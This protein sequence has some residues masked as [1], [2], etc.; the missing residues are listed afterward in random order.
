MPSRDNGRKQQ[1]RELAQM[2]T[3]V[4]RDDMA[5]IA[6]EA[7]GAAAR[8]KTEQELRTEAILA[9]LD[10]LGGAQVG[11]DSIVFA[12][13]RIILPEDMV[14]KMD[15]VVSFLMEY[16]ESQNTHFNISR[17]FPFRP[18]DVAAAFDRA[19]KRVF[20]VSGVGRAQFSFFGVT[21]PEYISVNAGPNGQ[22]IQVP[23]EKVEF[24]LLEA[25]FYLEKAKSPEHGVIGKIRVDA[26]KKH[27]KRIEGFF[28][29]VEEELHERSLYRGQAI[30]AHPTEPEFID[31]SAVD[32]KRVIYT[33]AVEEQLEV[34]LWAPLRYTQALR[35]TNI[36]LKRAVLLHGP[37]G[38]GK[39]LAGGLAGMIATQN[40]WTYILVRSQDDA[41]AALETARMYSPALVMI[42]DL[43]TMASANNDRDQITLVLDRLDNVQAKGAEVMV[44]FTSNHAA[45]L[46]KNVVRP[47]R[48]DAVIAVEA[49]DAQGYER[50]VK[51]L[52]PADL[53]DGD[54]DYA[55]VDE[56][57]HYTDPKGALKGFLPAFATEA[58]L[59]SMRYSIARNQ[60][61]PDTI[62]TADLVSAANGM[63][64]H[65]A[66]MDAASQADDAR[67]TL[68]EALSEVITGAM[69]N[70]VGSFEPKEE[71][72]D[73]H[74]I[75]NDAKVEFYEAD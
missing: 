49:L 9:T 10:Q 19:M 51:A 26:P 55:A 40:G 6:Q 33:E 39:T 48:L 21:P 20:G 61:R 15:K 35:D 36:P 24:S 27:R 52:I 18:Y 71:G 38:T 12:G 47:G 30:T 64:E 7:I 75:L 70:M 44:I 60:G 32:P 62:K 67:P 8:P 43:D 42:E 22:T 69:E 11:E 50:L 28:K 37:N 53:L 4:L 2:L 45:K 13:S 74:S 29:V 73:I 72:G 31:L 65:I 56:S 58:I 3:P 54:V 1:E 34:N 17:T 57:M 14:G 59:R 66:L 46:D 63:A 5:R 16:E 68:D 23:W 41:L 25:D